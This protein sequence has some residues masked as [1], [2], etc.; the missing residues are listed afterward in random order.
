M[1]IPCGTS[2]VSLGCGQHH[3][4]TS[5][6]FVLAALFVAAAIA[7]ATRIEIATLLLAALLATLLT[8]LASG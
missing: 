3:S 7:T 6:L 5:R 4:L 8:L 1:K 2:R